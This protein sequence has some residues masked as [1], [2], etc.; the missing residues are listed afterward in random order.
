MNKISLFILGISVLGVSLYIIITSL[1]FWWASGMIW[2]FIAANAF[3]YI[4][5]R[6]LNSEIDKLKEK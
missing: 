5:T 2:Q 4:G 6:L 3:C 1:G